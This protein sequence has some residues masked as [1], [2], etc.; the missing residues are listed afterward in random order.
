MMKART[1]FF[2]PALGQRDE[3]DDDEEI[4]IES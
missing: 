1:N 3:T 2:K 4:M